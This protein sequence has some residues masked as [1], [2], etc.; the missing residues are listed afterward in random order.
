MNE[1]GFCASRKNRLSD[2]L[3]YQDQNPKDA[4]QEQARLQYATQIAQ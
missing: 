1:S 3:E 4:T 2:R